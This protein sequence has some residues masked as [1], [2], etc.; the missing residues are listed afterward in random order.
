MQFKVDRIIKNSYG[1]EIG[2]Q[3]NGNFS[4]SFFNNN[5]NIKTKSLRHSINILRELKK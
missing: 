2:V 4:L 5:Y 1:G 3:F